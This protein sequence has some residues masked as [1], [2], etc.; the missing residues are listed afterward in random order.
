MR[1][2][3]V[4]N[5]N[6]KN[7][8]KISNAVKSKSEEEKIKYPKTVETMTADAAM[9]HTGFIDGLEWVI[10]LITQDSQLLTTNH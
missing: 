4:I 3:L 8:L 2:N 7:V 9:Y 5:H 1:E 6:N 10:K